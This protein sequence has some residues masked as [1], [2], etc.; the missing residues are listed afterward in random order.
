MNLKLFHF[1]FIGRC[2]VSFV[3]RVIILKFNLVLNIS[4]IYDSLF[5]MNL[6]LFHFHFVGRCVVSFVMR[7]IILKY[8]LVLNIS[9]IDDSLINMNLE[10]KLFHFHFVGRCMV[11]FILRVV[12]FFGQ[13]ETKKFFD[14]FD[15]H[16]RRSYGSLVQLKN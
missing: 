12:I 13:F 2:V 11:S 6:K 3:M 7:V 9:K 1:H 14:D 4:S 16:G 15:K 10:V 8:N 5:D